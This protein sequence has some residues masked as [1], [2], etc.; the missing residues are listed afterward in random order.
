MKQ[1][2]PHSVESEESLIV[3]VMMGCSCLDEVLEAVKADDFYSERNRIIFQAIERLYLKK[4]PIDLATVA[5]ALM[6]KAQLAEIGGAMTLSGMLDNAP[7]APNPVEYAR[8]IS[9]NAVVRKIISAAHEIHNSC[10]SGGDAGDLVSSAQKKILEINLPGSNDNFVGMAELVTS[11]VEEINRANKTKNSR[12]YRIGFGELDSFLHITGSKL[13]VVAARPMVGK[14]AFATSIM[15]NMA[16]NGFKIGFLSLEMAKDEIAKRMLAIEADVN[17]MRIGKYQGLSSEE[18]KKIKEAKDKLEAMPIIIDDQGSLSIEDVERK[19]RKLKKA[20]C[21]VIFIDQL[22]QISG[23]KGQSEF[24]RYTENCN[25]IAR[26]K[27]E[28]GLPIFLLCQI[29]READKRSNREPQLSDL[30]NTGSI[31]EDAD[32]VIL[33]H[34]P[35]ISEENPQKKAALSGKA[36][37]NIAKNRQGSPFR[38]DKIFFDARVTHY[39]DSCFSGNSI[40]YQPEKIQKTSDSDDFDFDDDGSVIMGQEAA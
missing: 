10:M 18:L 5:Q 16:N 12:G 2:L 19:C 28:L 3:A 7:Y 20:G 25:R 40:P 13:V 37:V 24:E 33:L 26:F 6:E 8:I 29:N 32:I 11:T 22:S 35:E 30:K 17:L 1:Q 31:E 38:D 39:R 21:Q 23:R 4:T 36:I 9:G 27:K 15:L 34:R 14:T